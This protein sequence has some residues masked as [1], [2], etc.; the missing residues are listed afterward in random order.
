[1]S[2]P[3]FDAVDLNLEVAA[4]DGK[5]QPVPQEHRIIA[6][7]YDDQ[8]RKADKIR[9]K[10]ANYDLHHIDS[11]IWRKGNI[12]RC[13]WGYGGVT[14]QPR[15]GTID[16]VTGGLELDI[17]ASGKE[18][19]AN[20]V[21]IDSAV[22]PGP[23]KRS[24]V[25]RII[26]RD[27]FGF[28]PD[29]MFI[30]DSLHEY[31]RITHARMTASQ[32][33]RAMADRL[34]WEY[35]V[36]FDGF[37]FHERRLDQKPQL[38]LR[39]HQ[40]DGSE[41]ISFNLDKSADAS[42]P[43]RIILKGRDPLTKEDIEIIVSNE[44][45]SGRHTLGSVVEMPSEADGENS[46]D[47]NAKRVG[48]TY[49]IPST[50]K[51]RASMEQQAKGIF[52]RVQ[53]NAISMGLTTRGVPSLLAK[54]TVTITGIGPTV[55]GTYYLTEVM[56]KVRPSPYLCTMKAKRDASTAVAHPAEPKLPGQGDG[57]ETSGNVNDKS[58]QT[59]GE[60]NPRVNSDGSTEFTTGGRNINF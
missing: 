57:V 55:D 1:M 5:F 51:D 39:F 12:V 48:T 25:A 9:I 28:T 7:S 52:K 17:E 41:I 6:F 36:D 27:V 8:E 20:K 59:T 15:E 18:L 33:L 34:G 37:H 60:L 21:M 40:G 56:H 47:P 50:L 31:P 14:S 43:G 22:Y 3:N 46:S 10:V 54:A 13:S 35:F 19:N 24:D 49:I 26:A 23:I 29:Q 38:E 45:E 53:L 58:P 4:E 44:T 11:P 16:K 30:Q 42:K 32:F 2:I